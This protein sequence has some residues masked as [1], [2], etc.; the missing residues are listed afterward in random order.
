[1]EKLKKLRRLTDAPPIRESL[2]LLLQSESEDICEDSDPLVRLS[3]SGGL[4]IRPHYCSVGL[5]YAEPEL[6]V[7][8]SL[9]LRLQA[10]AR[11]LPEGN[12]LIVLDGWRSEPLQREVLAHFRKVLPRSAD[13]GKYIFSGQNSQGY[14]TDAPPH[15]TGGAVDL[16]LG[17]REAKPL[18]MGVGFDEMI[19]LAATQAFE[20]HDGGFPPDKAHLF[21][22]HRRALVYAMSVA[23]FSNYPEEYWHYDFGNSF[24]R[25]YSGIP[26][27]GSFGVAE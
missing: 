12:T 4:L 21:R 13:L 11:V 6:R 19:S 3:E 2:A 17:D 9:S 25:F 23:G 15:R 10:A 16:T 18:A 1:M 14:P 22:T 5:R 24:W 8:R 26:G 27:C 7:R 20:D